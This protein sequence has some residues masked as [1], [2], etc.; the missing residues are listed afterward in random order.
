MSIICRQH[1]RAEQAQRGFVSVRVLLCLLTVHTLLSMLG[2]FV[3]TLHTHIFCMVMIG[4]DDDDDDADDD[5]GS[6]DEHH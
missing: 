4:A 6:G 2:V 1:V 3:C 5:G